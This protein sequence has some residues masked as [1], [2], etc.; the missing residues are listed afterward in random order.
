MDNHNTLENIDIYGEQVR[1]VLNR[2]PNWLTS[3]GSSILF[4]FITILGFLSYFVKYPDV[5]SGKVTITS[6]IPAI[7]LVVKTNGH[8]QKPF[9][10]DN[11]NVTVGQKLALLENTSNSDDVYNLLSLLNKIDPH[12]NDNSTINLPNYLKLGDIQT[13]YSNFV[14]EC[15][16]LKIYRSSDSKEKQLTVFN[17][18][19]DDFRQLIQQ[20]SKQRENLENELGIINRDVERNAILFKEGIVSSKDL[21]DKQK[22]PLRLKR[23]LEDI[24]IAQSNTQISI[25]NTER[26]IVELTSQNTESGNQLRIRLFEAYQNLMNKISEWEQLYVVKAPT[27]GV[28]SYF[29]FWSENQNV[30]QGD[31]IFSIIPKNQTEI[32]G[33]VLL[34]T[35]RAGKLQIGQKAIIKLDNFPYA[36]FGVIEGTVK[37]ISSIPKQNQY[38]VEIDFNN[39]LITNTG[40]TITAKNDIQ[41]SVDIV[42]EDLRLIE[43]VFYQIRKLFV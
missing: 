3:T 16:A 1:E 43:R 4:V 42:T 14:R 37:H 22:E 17:K 27:E 32:I 25:S 39:K 33:K 11:S 15:E 26:N 12:F 28:I 21:E 23:Q 7:N 41:G 30:K 38:A 5:L 20:Y 9:V 31:E 29:N 36:E 13:L 8:I 6:D 35:Q 34:S 18:Q 2:P 40:T 10:A 19:M 24:S